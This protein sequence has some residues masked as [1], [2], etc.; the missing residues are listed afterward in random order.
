MNF[1]NKLG[2]FYKTRENEVRFVV[3]RF[4]RCLFVAITDTN[5]FLPSPYSFEH[6]ICTEYSAPNISKNTLLRQQFA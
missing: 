6:L 4:I 2:D 3:I 1:S 5:S